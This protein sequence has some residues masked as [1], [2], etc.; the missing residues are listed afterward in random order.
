ML[1]FVTSL[2]HPHNS[3][4]YGRV[5]QLLQETLGSVTAQTSDDY[6]VY[7][8]GNRAPAFTLPDRTFFVPVDFAPPVDVAGP[9]FELGPFVRD[10]GTKIGIGLAAAREHR[11]DHV[12]IFD[13]DD[14]VHHDIA[15]LSSSDPDANGWL[16]E[17][18][19]IYSRARQAYQVQKR[20]FGVC[21][22]SHV[23]AWRAYDVPQD[24]PLTATQD[25]V[26]EAYGERL[27]ALLGAHRNK[28]IWLSK[29]GNKL[30]PMPFRG[31]VYQ[32]DTGENHSGKGLRGVA[33]P[34]GRE[35]TS[36]YGV[37]RL[38]SRVAAAGAA[39]APSELVYSARKRSADRRA[40]AGK[41][42]A[43]A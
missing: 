1:A 10:K 18:G 28:R 22:T 20:F 19:Y 13:A 37:P 29:H 31:A 3:A 36:T 11:P 4:D 32:V 38:R 40:R 41:A 34:L 35:L 8:V 6:V 7:V 15:A 9:Q 23:V 33:R 14:Y 24:L 39:W 2:R 26:A 27:G 30:D 43:S 5:E 16:V 25:E 21:G 17:E 12:M 42:A